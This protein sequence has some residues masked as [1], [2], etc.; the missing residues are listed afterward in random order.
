MVRCEVQGRGRACDSDDAL[1][2]LFSDVL[3][4]LLVACHASWVVCV[5]C[6]C[7]LL[8]S[9]CR[10]LRA[11]ARRWPVACLRASVAAR[12][13]P[14]CQCQCGVWW[15]V[16]V[17][18]ASLLARRRPPTTRHQTGAGIDTH[19]AYRACTPTPPPARQSGG[20][21]RDCF[22][23]TIT[24][25]NHEHGAA[26]PDGPQSRKQTLQQTQTRGASCAIGGA[27][28]N[29]AAVVTAFTGQPEVKSCCCCPP[30]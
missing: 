11:C 25:T 9:Y 30:P 19:S 10:S 8:S 12:H 15:W 26:R 24:I 1:S 17:D 4:A 6:F 13:M 23:V 5:R 2:L 21:R 27:R 20:A 3:W 28:M 18:L 16:V 7:L 22:L 29:L 14:T